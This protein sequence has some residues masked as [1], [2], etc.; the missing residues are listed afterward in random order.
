MPSLSKIRAC[1][2][3]LLQKNMMPRSEARIRTTS[4]DNSLNKGLACSHQL[5]LAKLTVAILTALCEAYYTRLCL[6]V[7]LCP[8]IYV[9]ASI[10]PSIHPSIQVCERKN[11]R[12]RHHAIQLSNQHMFRYSR[13]TAAKLPITLL[14]NTVSW[15]LLLRR[16][17]SLKFLLGLGAG[18]RWSLEGK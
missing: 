2:K 7:L 16:T 5:R 9:H 18:L 13:F 8:A 6:W 1:S 11:R 10:H 14:E 15:L 3:S 17:G 12:H 4:Q